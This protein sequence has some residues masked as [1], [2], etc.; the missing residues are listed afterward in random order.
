MK[1]LSALLSGATSGLAE[2]S[3]SARAD[4]TLL[5]ANVLGRNRAWVVAHGDA[6][7][8]GEEAARFETF[9]AQRRRGVPVAYLLGSTGFC[10]RA[11]LVNET[12]LVPRPETEHLVEEALRFIRGSMRALDVGSGC[13]AIACTIAAETCATVD[14]T[15]TS[16]AAI[17]IARKN[18]ERLGVADRCNFYR[19][20]LA[21]PVRH[22]H[23]DVVVANLPYIPTA[24]LPK[25]P[26]PASFEP[27]EALDGGPDGLTLYRE[28]LPQLP[29]LLNENALVLLE[30]APPTINQLMALVRSTFPNFA[31]EVGNDYAGLA[32]YIRAE[33]RRS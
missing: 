3:P 28:L 6:V 13:G 12:V 22:N 8:S 11:F 2:S 29:P 18:A 26:E 25:P 1:T 32:R 33:G 23:Y 24:E 7:A 17:E 4:A 10:G 16:A 5:L 27:R 20:D 9:C 14:A 31:V 30:S 21:G 15:D 19:G